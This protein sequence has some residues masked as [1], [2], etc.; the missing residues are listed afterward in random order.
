VPVV[1]AAAFT[2]DGKCAV[3]L[4]D[5]ELLVWNLADA[6]LIDQRKILA[7]STI[8]TCAAFSSDCRKL[9]VGGEGS[10]RNVLLKVDLADVL[11]G[12]AAAAQ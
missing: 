1:H 3:A 5:K 4:V 6:R 11:P 8:P 2:A 9:V 12:K 10:Q 7:H